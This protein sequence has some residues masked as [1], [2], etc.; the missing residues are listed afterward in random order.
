M[1]FRKIWQ[2]TTKKKKE[3]KK[4]EPD[5]KTSKVVTVRNVTEMNCIWAVVPTARMELKAVQQYFKTAPV[6][7]SGV[8]PSTIQRTVTAWGGM[9]GRRGTLSK[10][11]KTVRHVLKKR[12]LRPET[13]REARLRPLP[14]FKYF[15]IE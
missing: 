15:T 9:R 3:R 7:T 4:V 13:A 2:T 1:L 10:K 8:P 6:I 14:I 5:D 12:F 11:V